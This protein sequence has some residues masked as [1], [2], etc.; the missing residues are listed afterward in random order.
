MQKNTTRMKENR[1]SLKIKNSETQSGQPAE[2][3]SWGRR[4][5]WLG[6]DLQWHAK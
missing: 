1:Q 4:F 2:G 5:V 6:S 3:G